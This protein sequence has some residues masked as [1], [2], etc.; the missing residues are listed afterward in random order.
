MDFKTTITGV[1]GTALSSFGALAQAHEIIE[2]ISL[3]VTILGAILTFIVMPLL[4]WYSKAKKDD[5]ITVDEIKE[6]VETLKDGI[7]N[8]EKEIKDEEN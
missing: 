6:G 7:E 2:L 5:K 8:V 4:N 1:I 3:I